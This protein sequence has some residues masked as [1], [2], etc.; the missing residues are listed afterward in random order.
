MSRISL[1]AITV[2]LISAGIA[3]AALTVSIVTMWRTHFA[4]PRP[5]VIAGRL[6]FRIYPIRSGDERWYIGSYDLPISVCNPGTQPLLLTELRLRLHFP[7]VPI[8]NNEELIP[9]KWEIE[10]ESSSKI[11]HSRFDWIHELGPNDWMPIPVLPKATVLRHVIFE[12][13]WS[14]PIIQHQVDV[15]LQVRWSGSKKRLVAGAWKTMLDATLW[16]ELTNNGTSMSYSAD[17]TEVSH[18]MCN[19]PDLHK[20]TGSKEPIPAKGFDMGPS[21]LDFPKRGKKSSS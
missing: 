10:P 7:K 4:M 1:D 8:P 20:Y 3:L 19:P 17:G 18:E 14:D 16:G 12:T 11:D 2:A 9:A 15:E 21:Y 13:C 6:R 5:I